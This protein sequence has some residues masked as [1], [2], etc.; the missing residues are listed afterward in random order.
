MSGWAPIPEIGS[1]YAEATVKATADMNVAN[2]FDEDLDDPCSTCFELDAAS[3][4]R[5]PPEGQKEETIRSLVSGITADDVVNRTG[6]ALY[7][8]ANSE[9]LGWII[10]R[11]SGRPLSEW[12]IEIVEAAVLEGCFHMAS[13]RDGVPMLSGGACLSARDLARNG[14]LFARMG[15]WVDGRAWATPPSSKIRAAIPALP[16]YRTTG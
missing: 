6:Y 8:S 10:E 15:E 11:V 9:V 2:D 7:K 12:L 13:D 4:L 3:G 1:G 14:L 5:L 16:G